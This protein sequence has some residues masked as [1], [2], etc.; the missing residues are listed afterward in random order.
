MVYYF[1]YVSFIFIDFCTY[2]YIH[3]CIHTCIRRHIFITFKDKFTNLFLTQGCV[4]RSHT[5]QLAK[6]VESCSCWIYIY[7]GRTEQKEM[8]KDQT[9]CIQ[10][11]YTEYA[12]NPLMSKIKSKTVSMGK[13]L[14]GKHNFY[15][16][17][18]ITKVYKF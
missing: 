4:C 3:T 16:R 13:I 17:C 12:R 7:T 6:G 18:L 10:T 5:L 11:L 2:S 1:F 9:R 15:C 8:T 14:W